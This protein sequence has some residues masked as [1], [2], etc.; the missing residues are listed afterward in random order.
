VSGLSPYQDALTDRPWLELRVAKRGV[1]VGQRLVRSVTCID[2]DRGLLDAWRLLESD[3]EKR[4]Q[5]IHAG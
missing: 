4:G 3:A 5:A 1:H 2:C